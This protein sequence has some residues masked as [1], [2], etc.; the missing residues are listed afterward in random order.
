[1]LQ[2]KILIVLPVLMVA[3]EPIQM[4]TLTLAISDDSY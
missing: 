1:M 4:L 2:A 3:P